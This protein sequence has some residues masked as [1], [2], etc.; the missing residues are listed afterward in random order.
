M[1]VVCNALA[2]LLAPIVI[3]WWLPHDC[4]TPCNLHES[5][6]HR[7]NAFTGGAKHMVVPVLRSGGGFRYV[8]LDTG[9]IPDE[10]FQIRERK[11]GWCL[12]RQNGDALPVQLAPHRVWGKQD[13]QRCRHGVGGLSRRAKPSQHARTL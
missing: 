13:R 7:A 6:R 8:Y 12:Q 2:S 9:L 4:V 1:L 5:A 11:T 10:I 3:V